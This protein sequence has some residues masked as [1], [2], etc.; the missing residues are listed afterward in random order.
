MISTS[1]QNPSSVSP[2]DLFSLAFI[3]S[4]IIVSLYCENVPLFRLQPL[5]NIQNFEYCHALKI[6]AYHIFRFFQKKEKLTS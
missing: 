2:Q 5:V 4:L 1:V 6:M 3:M